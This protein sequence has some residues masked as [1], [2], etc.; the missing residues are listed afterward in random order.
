MACFNACT[1]FCDS[2]VGAEGSTGGLV[3]GKCHSHT[4]SLEGLGEIGFSTV[5][6][7]LG[8]VGSHWP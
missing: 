1:L 7:A 3:E 6:P 2:G 4:G 8:K 5:G